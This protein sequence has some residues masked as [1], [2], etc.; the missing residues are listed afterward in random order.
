MRIFSLCYVFPNPCLLLL[1]LTN[2]SASRAEEYLEFHGLFGD[3]ILSM[4][5]GPWPGWP[6]RDIIYD[7]DT[8]RLSHAAVSLE[9]EGFWVPTEWCSR[10]EKLDY[11]IYK[12]DYINLT[13]FTST[14][15]SS[16]REQCFKAN[17]LAL[18]QQKYIQRNLMSVKVA[19]EARG[20]KVFLGQQTY[21]DS[22]RYGQLAFHDK[23][24]ELLINPRDYAPAR[25]ILQSLA[26]QPTSGMLFT[27]VNNISVGLACDPDEEPVHNTSKPV[28]GPIGKRN[29][30]S[31]CLIN[32]T[33]LKISG[34]V[35]RD[36]SRQNFEYRPLYGV[37]FQALDNDG[38]KP[39]TQFCF[40]RSSNVVESEEI[41]SILDRNLL[42]R[43]R[44][45]LC[46]HIALPCYLLDDLQ[47]RSYTFNY[48]KHSIELM[49]TMENSTCRWQSAFVKSLD[50]HYVYHHE[51]ELVP[52]ITRIDI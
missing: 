47:P 12:Q 30:F 44:K 18:K 38:A 37:L 14:S 22:I 52:A 40:T 42:T 11:L 49:L 13:R 16:L 26:S 25:D 43:G 7:K 4:L 51:D 9:L 23:E 35:A 29:V 15:L 5:Y 2:L 17:I 8:G 20:I 33:F 45:L 39:Q 41:I 19:L 28:L 3:D 10:G 46:N 34:E 48:S 27:S 1:F 50:P 36:Q 32:V 24:I 6:A 31:N 21:L